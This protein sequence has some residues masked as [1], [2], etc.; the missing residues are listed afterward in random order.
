MHAHRRGF[1]LILVLI[2]VAV[3][4]ALAMHSAVSVRTTTV[5]ARVLSERDETLRGARNAAVLVLLGLITSPGQDSP[6]GETGPLSSVGTGP[7]SSASADDAP[8]KPDIELPPIIREIIGDALDGVE[9]EARE[10]TSG[11]SRVAR[12][13]DGG[14]VTGRTKGGFI[15]LE[16]IGLPVEP[17]PVSFAGD[18]RTYRV[19]LKDPAGQID[20]NDASPETLERLLTEHSVEQQ[21]ARAIVDQ[22]VDWRDDDDFVRPAGAEQSVYSARGV[23][24]RNAPF[25]AREEL[26]YLPAMTPDVFERIRDDLTTGSN[27]SIHAGSASRAV[28][29][30]LPGMLP[31]VAAEIVRVRATK[32]LTEE[33]LD[34]LVPISAREARAMLRAA[35]SNVVRIRV[36]AQGDSVLVYEGLA[37]LDESGIRAMGLRPM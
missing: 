24:C 17:L 8:K 3:V 12:A 22:I 28:L 25:R 23:A 7:G 21:Q 6:L 11:S 14:G 26:L 31:A 15:L 5:E 18:L 30:S 36:E 2:S 34:S 16:K 1:A 33:D 4:F 9:D 29:A 32:Q 13:V 20:L 27:G 19:S 37:F 35:P 10:A